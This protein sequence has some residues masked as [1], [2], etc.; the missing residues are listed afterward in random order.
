MSDLRQLHDAAT[1][2]REALVAWLGD[3]VPPYADEVLHDL[4]EVTAQPEP[5]LPKIRALVNEAESV[6]EMLPSIPPEWEPVNRAAL[7]AGLAPAK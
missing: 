6:M 2:L 5:D 7:A 3:L 1:A 4:Q